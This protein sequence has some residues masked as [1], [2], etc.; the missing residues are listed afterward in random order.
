MLQ[1][2]IIEP[3]PLEPVLCECPLDMIK[4]IVESGLKK[5]HARCGGTLPS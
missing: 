4:I 3:K 1:R 2:L 5:V